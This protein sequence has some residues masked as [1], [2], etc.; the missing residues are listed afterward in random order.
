MEDLFITEKY[1]RANMKISLVM[2]TKNAAQVRDYIG[3]ALSI[4]PLFDEVIVHCNSYA[5]TIWVPQ[6]RNVTILFEDNPISC[7]DA[8]NKCVGQASGDWVLP[9]CDDDYCDVTELEKLVIELK[10]G[11][12]QDKDIVYSPFYTGNEKDGWEHW[13]RKEVTLEALKIHNMLP[14][15]SFYKH[16][17]W[18]DIKGYKNM[19]FNDWLFWLEAAKAGKTFV[20]WD[21]AYFYFRHGHVQAPSLSD[22]EAEK[23]PFEVTRQQLLAYLEKPKC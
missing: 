13:P 21:K 10:A 18:D 7:P 3:Q 8:L 11:L 4:S 9:L 16:K 14:F 6:Y 2:A 17:V 19:L 15:T 22:Q 12:H 5:S 23:Q 1:I 20:L